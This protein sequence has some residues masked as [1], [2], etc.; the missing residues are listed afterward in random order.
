LTRDIHAILSERE[1][2]LADRFCLKHMHDHISEIEHI[3]MNTNG[4]ASFR[5]R[6][7]KCGKEED[8]TDFRPG[9]ERRVNSESGIEFVKNR[10][11]QLEQMHKET[12]DARKVSDL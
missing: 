10:L 4:I 3:F 11:R 12:N 2:D 5:I 6:C 1:N 7:V 8:L 9:E